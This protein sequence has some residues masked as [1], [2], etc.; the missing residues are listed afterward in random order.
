[1]KFTWGV[2]KE[3]P[4]EFITDNQ[5]GSYGHRGIY[6]GTGDAGQLVQPEDKR[7]DNGDQHMKSKER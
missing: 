7:R 6:T 4:P 5:N 1:M 3:K 2:T